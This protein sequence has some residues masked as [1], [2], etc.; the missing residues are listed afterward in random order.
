[1]SAELAR[2]AI[3]I[4]LNGTR[5]REQENAGVFLLFSRRFML[6]IVANAWSRWPEDDEDYR[7]RIIFGLAS[8]LVNVDRNTARLDI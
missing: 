4:A 8:A 3:P 5:E 7:I 2:D 6:F 1:M